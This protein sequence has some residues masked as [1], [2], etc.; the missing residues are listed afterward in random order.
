MAITSEGINRVRA[1][2]IPSGIWADG[3]YVATPRLA[4]VKW[5]SSLND[6]YYQVYV[7]CKYAGTTI[8]STQ[9]EMLV[10]IPTSFES[11]VRIEVFA[12]TREEA[13][14]DFNRNI[15]PAPASTDRVALTMLRSQN[16]PIGATANIYYDAGE[17]EIDYDKPTNTSPIQIWPSWL[18]KAGFGMSKFGRND[19]GWDSAAAVGFGKGSFGN[20]HFG[21][22]ADTFEWISEPLPL[23]TY[24]FGVKVTDENGRESQASETEPIVVTPAA[25]PAEKLSI[26]SFDKQVNQLVLKIESA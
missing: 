16:L 23:G 4:L 8:D 3:N 21:L 12:V 20:G 9:R 14:I 6:M 19:F 15:E 25:R 1:Y 2:Q 10:H 5:H 22:D 24:K 26:L 11:A 17:G 7:N 13:Y 18:D